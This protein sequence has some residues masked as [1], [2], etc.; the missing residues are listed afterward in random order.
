MKIKK[1]LK[2]KWKIQNSASKSKVFVKS[3]RNKNLRTKMLFHKFK[4]WYSCSMC[5][6]K[7]IKTTTFS[8]ILMFSFTFF[9]SETNFWNFGL[10]EKKKFLITKTNFLKYEIKNKST[11]ICVMNE[12]S[13]CQKSFIFF[14]FWSIWYS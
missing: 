1:F 11:F 14:C 10:F 2:I 13:F 3:N 5:I 12:N 4:K 8:W 7:T 9:I 6:F